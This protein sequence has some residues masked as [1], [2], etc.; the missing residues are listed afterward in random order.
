MKLILNAD[1]T[2]SAECEG[3][4]QQELIKQ[5]AFWHGLPTVCPVDGSAVR[6]GYREG[7]DIPFYSLLSTGERV[8]EFPLGQGTGDRGMFAGKMDGEGKQ[9]KFVQRWQY[10]DHEKQGKVVVWENGRLLMETPSNVHASSKAKPV[11]QAPVIEHRNITD[12]SQL[13]TLLE[14]AQALDFNTIPGA[15]TDA[16]KIEALGVA[17]YG[18]KRTWDTKVKGLCQHFSA[19]RS[20]SVET[21]FPPEIGSMLAKMQEKV[22][23][24]YVEKAGALYKQGVQVPNV[25]PDECKGLA[26]AAAYTKLCKIETS[27]QV[28]A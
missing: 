2:W 13:D 3:D 18:D 17:M 5:A 6:F 23:I 19:R 15:V 12:E 9:K 4:T 22:R 11:V 14:D 10:Y 28:A 1:G 20:M 7:D 21:L 25:D 8:Y 27:A 24:A 16:D 26:L